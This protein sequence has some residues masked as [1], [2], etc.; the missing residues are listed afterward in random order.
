[1]SGAT[2]GEFIAQE[3]YPGVINQSKTD[4]EYASVGEQSGLFAGDKGFDITVGKHTQL[5]GAVIASTAEASKNSLDTGTLGWSSLDNH[6][7]YS[8]SSKGISAGGATGQDSHGGQMFSGGGVPLIG[9]GA[10]DNAS[11]T[12][13][14]AI[15]AG[16]I[17]I[18]DKEHQQQDVA[19]LSRDTDNAN[20]HIDK[21]FDKEKI[22]EQQELAAVF[23]QMANQYAGDLG[24]AMGWAADGPEKAAIHG[25]IGAIQASFGGGN[26][27]AGGLAGMGSEALGQFVDDYLSSNTQLGVNE[28]AAITQWAAALG[29]AAVGG[30]TGGSNGAMSGAATALDSVRYNYLDHKEAE[31]KKQVEHQLANGE[32]NPEERQVLQQELADINATDKARDALIGDIC[33]QGNKSSAACTQLVIKA[34]TALDSYGGA[35]TYNLS[36]KDIFPKDYANAAAIME[37]LDA[38]NITRDAAISGIAQSTGKPWAEVEKAYDDAMQLHGIVSIIAGYKVAGDESAQGGKGSVKP[39]AAKGTTAGNKISYVEEPPYNPAGTGGAAQPWSTKGRIKYVELPTSGK[40]RYVPPEDYSAS[41]PLPRGPNNGYFDK[42]GNEWVKGPSRTAGQ[43]FEWDVQ[44]SRTG[45]AQL[46]WATRDGSHLNIS[47][48]GKI[49]HK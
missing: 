30:V 17:T 18:R 27:L 19:D 11:G 6:A 9:I 5:D 29:G 22:E 40:I 49:T 39:D 38:G 21:I 4:S 10:S 1:L 42:F 14:S 16:T 37:G 3:M 32:L 48:D 35:A 34:Q 24:A 8:A 31:R 23:G 25:V 28:K 36:Y 47:L 46:G 33:T 7:E 26:A 20:G 41:Q 44:L 15:A 2:I 43:A 13:Q 45:K 12:T